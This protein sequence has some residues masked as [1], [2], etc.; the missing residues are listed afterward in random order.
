MGTHRCIAADELGAAVG[1]PLAVTFI[2]VAL[3][4]LV[5]PPE[6]AFD[7]ECSGDRLGRAR[8][9]PGRREDLRRAEQRLRGH[10]GPVRALAAHE[11][12]L[13]ERHLKIAFEPAQRP[14]ERLARRAAAEDDDARHRLAAEKDSESAKSPFGSSHQWARSKPASRSSCLQAVATELVRDLGAQ[15]LAGRELHLEL[16]LRDAHA[17]IDVGAEEHLDPL[18][19]GV[20]ARD[21]RESRRVEVAAELAV[22]HVQHVA[23]ELRCD[24]ARVVVRGLEPRRVLDEVGAEQ[25]R[26]AGPEQPVQ[27]CEERRA[28]LA[29]E[30]ADARSRGTRTAAA[31]LRAAR[32]GGA[33]SRRRRRAPRCPGTRRRSSPRP[34]AALAPR[35]RRE[36]S[37]SGIRPRP[38]RRA[39]AAS[40]RTIPSRARRACSPPSGGATSR[41]CSAR[42]MRSRPSGSTRAAW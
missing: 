42:M 28:L 4:D 9:L 34:P 22:D 31:V 37:A 16:E 29:G 39:G 15:L 1:E 14:D 19:L 17:L 3:D 33:R 27:V 12:A 20:P 24:A 21:V 10:A 41:A 23:V 6:D 26:L 32:R 5:S 36:R 25:E 40:S 11:R 7:V 2:L 35:R 38:S 30:V 18:V 13:D 8:R